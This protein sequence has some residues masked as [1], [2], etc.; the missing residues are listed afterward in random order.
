MDKQKKFHELFIPI[1]IEL[2]FMMLIGFADT[3]MLSAVGDK[4]VGAVGTSNTYISI[5]TLAFNIICSGMTAVMTQYIGAK[6]EHIAQKA[7]QIGLVINTII[8]TIISLI[9]LI[10]A[11]PILVGMS[12]SPALEED[13]VVYTTLIGGSAILT[14]VTPIYSYHLRAFGRTKEP[15]ITTLVANLVNIVFNAIFIYGL[16]MGVYGAAFATIISRV[17]NLVLN[18]MMSYIYIKKDNRACEISN[19]VIISQIVKIGLPAALETGMYNVSMM[20]VMMMINKMD[21]NGI[22][23]TI[24]SYGSTITQFACMS[25]VAIASANAIIIGW[26]CGEGKIEECYK[27]TFKHCLFA[28]IFGMSVELIVALLGYPIMSLMSKDSHIIKTVQIILF[29]D[30]ALE[31][32]RATNIV[33]GQA[34]KCTGDALFTVIISI[35]FTLLFAVGFTFIFGVKLK[36]F[37][38]GSFIGLASDEIARGICMML[39][40]KSRKWENKIFVKKTLDNLNKNEN[41]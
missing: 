14:A 4:T 10:F 38:I 26:K 8:G 40:W 2:F 28:I 18:M 32:G 31:L 20:L 34:L 36:M 16:K 37:V 17:I 25:S 30:I 7:C 3:T 5:F 29:I 27:L 12:I 19:K 9:F 21:I 24:K 22:N 39:R 41:E 23:A 11:R 15:L 13:A 6:K 1:Y 33:M 35:L